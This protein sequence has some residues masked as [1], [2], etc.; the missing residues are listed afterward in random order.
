[1]RC[2]LRACKE[3]TAVLDKKAVLV[4]VPGRKASLLAGLTPMSRASS[5]AT[6]RGT[7]VCTHGGAGASLK[8]VEKLFLMFP[9]EARPSSLC[10]G[11]QD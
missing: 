7:Y 5:R 4:R 8:L 6:R 11:H 1:M 10:A 3:G 9:P 2:L